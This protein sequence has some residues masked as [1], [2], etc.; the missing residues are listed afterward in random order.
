MDLSDLQNSAP[1]LEIQ[2][3]AL[4]EVLLQ[5]QRGLDLLFMTQEGLCMA[6]GETC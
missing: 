1:Y 5:N 6:L 3:G 4:A 2:L